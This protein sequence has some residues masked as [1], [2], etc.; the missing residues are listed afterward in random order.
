MINILMNQKPG[1]TDSVREFFQLKKVKIHW[2]NFDIFLIFAQNIDCGYTLE[3]PT[4][5]VLEQKKKEKQVY[6]CIPQFYYI[7][8]GFKGVYFTRT[9]FHDDITFLILK[10]KNSEAVQCCVSFFFSFFSI[11]IPIF[12]LHTRTR[13]RRIL[14]L[15]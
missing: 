8:V 13:S 2:K 12:N 10:S 3:P 6:S 14:V 11:H 15:K 5:Y 7:K 4:I 9:C 1:L